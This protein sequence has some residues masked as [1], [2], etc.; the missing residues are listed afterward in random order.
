VIVY[1]RGYP[2]PR[3]K[4]TSLNKINLLF[5]VVQILCVSCEVRTECLILT[6]LLTSM[7]SSLMLISNSIERIMAPE[8]LNSSA[9]NLKT[10][11]SQHF[12]FWALHSHLHSIEPTSSRTSEH[13]LGT[14]KPGKLFVSSSNGWGVS[15]FRLSTVFLSVLH[16]L[17]G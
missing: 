17:K 4:T 12:T 16:N 3:L 11:T 8:R 14:S 10:A 9:H 15:L 7:Q 6:T 1:P 13:S 5:S 2:Y